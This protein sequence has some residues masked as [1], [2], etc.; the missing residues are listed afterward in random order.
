MEIKITKR[1]EIVEAP[2]IY[3]HDELWDGQNFMRLQPINVLSDL[4]V[5]VMKTRKRDFLFNPLTI[6]SG[7]HLSIDNIK[8]GNRYN[9]GNSG[10][11]GLSFPENAKN[12]FTSIEEAN[13][14]KKDLIT[15]FED[16]AAKSSFGPKTKQA[17]KIN[18]HFFLY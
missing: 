17:G 11:R 3:I 6:K 12:F 2:M 7:W 13:Q 15:Y 14:A 8:V 9:H 18:N 10:K 1:I 4:I 5:S 16:L